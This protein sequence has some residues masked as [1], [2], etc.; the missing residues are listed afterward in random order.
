MRALITHLHAFVRDVEFTEAEWFAAIDFLTRTGQKCDDERQEFILLSDILGV[1]ML[2]DEVNHSKVGDLTETTIFGPFYVE[3]APEIEFGGSIVI[4]DDGGEATLI[5]GRVCS[6]DG[7]PLAGA[8]LDVWQT[9]SNASYD[10]QDPDQPD[11]NMRGKFR[12]ND[13]GEYAFVTNK[14]VSYP[15]PSDGPVGELLRAVD[16]H[17]NRPAHTHFAVSAQGHGSIITHLFVAG[18]PYLESDAVFGVKNSL[19]VPFKTSEDEELARQFGLAVPFAHAEYDFVL[20][21]N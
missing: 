2:V 18:D 9:A 6:E 19:I 20:E 3:G 16:R 13:N 14:P 5:T 10:V 4:E 15:I 21:A 1:S 8:R 11:Y 17:P 12:T 7:E